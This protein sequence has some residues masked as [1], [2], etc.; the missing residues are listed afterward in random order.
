MN[1]PP[2]GPAKQL[3]EEDKRQLRNQHREQ[4]KNAREEALLCREQFKE[5]T[6]RGEIGDDLYV[7]TSNGEKHLRVL[8]VDED[9]E[10]DGFDLDRLLRCETVARGTPCQVQVVSSSRRVRFKYDTPSACVV[11]VGS[12]WGKRDP[13]WQ[14]VES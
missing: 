2:T 13:N 12:A 9:P 3:T 10:Y 8:E 14:G 1:G 4:I 6:A 11:N 5:Q 7:D